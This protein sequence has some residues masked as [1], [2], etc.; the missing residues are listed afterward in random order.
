M[1]KRSETVPSTVLHRLGFRACVRTRNR[2]P[3]GRKR[4]RA[5]FSGRVALRDLVVGR[6]LIRFHHKRKVPHP[7]SGADDSAPFANGVRDDA[8]WMC[9]AVLTHPLQPLVSKTTEDIHCGIVLKP[10]SLLVSIGTGCTMGSTTSV[11]EAP[12]LRTT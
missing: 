9:R 6:C 1:G 4:A 2:H 8:F 3:D 5:V 12:I 10:Q 11:A 7:Y